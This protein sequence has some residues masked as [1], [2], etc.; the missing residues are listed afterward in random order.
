LPPQYPFKYFD[1]A[2]IVQIGYAVFDHSRL[3]FFSGNELGGAYL[4]VF[5]WFKE[6]RTVKDKIK[7]PF[8]AVVALNENWGVMATKYPNRTAAWG[9]CCDTPKFSVV[10]EFLN[11]PMT[12]MFVVNQHTNYTHP[13]LLSLPRGVPL[14]FT[15]TD[16]Y[17]FDR[18]DGVTCLSACRFCPL[19]NMFH[20]SLHRCMRR[21]TRATDLNSPSF[22]QSF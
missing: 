11:H 2:P 7:R 9:K 8:I 15:H 14:T 4:N 20:F 3:G 5:D 21:T 1:R 17:I 18:W 10:R 6:W 12:L 16:K 19:N 22:Y 13:K